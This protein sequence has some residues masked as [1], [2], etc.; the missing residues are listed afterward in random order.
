[1]SMRVVLDTNCLVSAL[2]FSKGRLAQLRH[3]WQAG[4]F[5][6]LVCEETMREL[7][8]VLAYPKFRLEKAD[9][10]ALLADFL[11]WVEVVTLAEA[12]SPVAQLRDKDDAVFIQL[13]LQTKA[14]YLV[15]GDRHLTE[16]V[17]RVT[18]PILSAADFLNLFDGQI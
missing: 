10:D 17:D 3:T 11:P 8:R 1:M 15:S 7:I 16:L 2:V 14:D 5:V 9:I 13:A 12:T 6:P 18:I 4:L